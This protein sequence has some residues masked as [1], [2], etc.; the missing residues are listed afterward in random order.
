MSHLGL[1]A[2]MYLLLAINSSDQ[3]KHENKKESV[4]FCISRM[5]KEL[6]FWKTSVSL[7][8]MIS[9]LVVHMRPN[10]CR[11]WIAVFMSSRDAGGIGQTYACHQNK[12]H[13]ITSEAYLKLFIYFLWTNG[14]GLRYLVNVSIKTTS[15]YADPQHPKEHPKWKL[16]QGAT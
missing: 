10:N 15:Q 5:K 6:K 2:K 14:N 4:S 11:L 16:L 13:D 8:Q 9:R 1:A 12:Y 7:G 3:C